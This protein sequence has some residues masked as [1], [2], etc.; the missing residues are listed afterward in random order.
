MP[1]DLADIRRELARLAAR[2]AELTAAIERA[3]LNATAED[4]YLK[5][6]GAAAFLGVSR[7]KVYDLMSEG[8][9]PYAL[10]GGVRLIARRAI[11]ELAEGRMRP[12][13]R[14]GGAG[15]AKRRVDRACREAMEM[16]GWPRRRAGGRGAC[17][18]GVS[19]RRCGPRP[20]ATCA[21]RTGSCPGPPPP[22]SR[23]A[24]RSRRCP[25]LPGRRTGGTASAGGV[26]PSPASG[27]GSATVPPG[28]AGRFGL[29][30]V[31]M[32]RRA[33]TPDAGAGWSWELPVLWFMP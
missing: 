30:S 14:H 3:G 4:G 29:A 15:Q 24:R 17:C 16:T 19:R 33:R 21:S 20:R 26:R 8:T 27:R 12:D 28:W 18:A 13:T 23:R 32:S 5:V 1:D 22:R 7:S 6:G 31:G 11:A 2:V 10:I 25:V 9:L